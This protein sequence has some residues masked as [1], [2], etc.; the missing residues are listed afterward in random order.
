MTLLCGVGQR[1]REQSAPEALYAESDCLRQE[2]VRCSND[3]SIEASGSLKVFVT[4][5]TEL[6][7]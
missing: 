4:I 7:A 6:N 3:D 1:G 5:F 2:V